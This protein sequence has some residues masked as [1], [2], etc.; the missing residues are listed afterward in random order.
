MKTKRNRPALNL[1]GCASAKKAPLSESRW[2][3]RAS[4][5]PFLSSARSPVMFYFPSRRRHTR[6]YGG[7]SSDVCS[8]DLFGEPHADAGFGLEQPE[9]GGLLGVVGLRR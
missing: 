3:R 1:V 8:S 5:L 6:S 7:W 2:N 4:I 9:Q